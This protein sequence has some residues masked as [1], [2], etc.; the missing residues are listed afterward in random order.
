MENRVFFLY[1]KKNK[2]GEL[3]YIVIY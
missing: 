3:Y 2:N 1:N